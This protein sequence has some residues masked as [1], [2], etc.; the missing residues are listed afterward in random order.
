[1]ERCKPLLRFVTAIVYGLLGLLLS[2]AVSVKVQADEGSFMII[3]LGKLVEFV[4][5]SVQIVLFAIAVCLHGRAWVLIVQNYEWA[6]K[7][8]SPITSV[9]IFGGLE[10]ALCLASFFVIIAGRL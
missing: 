9:W 3:N 5:G 4:V 7:N 10:G 1:M 8:E 6:R 2:A